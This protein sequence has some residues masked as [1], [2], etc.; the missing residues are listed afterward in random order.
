MNLKILLPFEILV[1]QNDVS[2]IVVETPN[3]SM[4]LLEHRLDCA[5]AL[6][7]GILSYQSQS[8]GE[9]FIAVDEGVLVKTASDV[10]VSVRRA[11]RGDSLEQLHATVKKEFLTLND[12]EIAMRSVMAKLESGFL[13]Q[14]ANFKQ[15]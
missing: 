2:H 7:P 12:Q 10:M 1:N 5:A 9:V 11:I 8:E 13:R 6:L 4:G 3:G 15:P 14:F